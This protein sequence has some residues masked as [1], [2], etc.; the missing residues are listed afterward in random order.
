MSILCHLSFI[1][2][3]NDLVYLYFKDVTD[4]TRYFCI[5]SP[6][7]FNIVCDNFDANKHYYLPKE[8]FK[9][10]FLFTLENGVYT[11]TKK[12]LD[13]LKYMLSK[14]C[15]LVSIEKTNGQDYVYFNDLVST[16]K[17]YVVL[18]NLIKN[19]NMSSNKNIE[20]YNLEDFPEKIKGSL[21]KFS[22]TPYGLKL[23]QKSL[24]QFQYLFTTYIEFNA[25]P[26]F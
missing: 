10:R 3:S 23:D 4:R 14:I 5:P 21:F 17:Y 9:S 16:S 7:D 15:I 25:A 6:E 22:I 20:L 2:K 24:E 1:Q 13:K 18:P 12:S 11:L 19:S 8:Y 26:P